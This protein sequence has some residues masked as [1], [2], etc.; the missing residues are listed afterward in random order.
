MYKYEHFNETKEKTE[1]VGN[2]FAYL[3]IGAITIYF[4][5]AFISQF[6]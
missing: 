5:V 2:L 6:V 1:T 3:I 4:G